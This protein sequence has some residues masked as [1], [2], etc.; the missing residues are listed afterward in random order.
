MKFDDFLNQAWNDHAAQP[1]K[2]SKTCVDAIKLIESDEQIPQLAQII[3]HVFGEHLGKWDEG[4]EALQKLRQIPALKISSES[5]LAILRYVRCLELAS[6]C[7]SSMDNFSH[8]DQVRIF[9]V[10]AS[11]LSGQNQIERAH[12]FF[13]RAVDCAQTSVSKDD[14]ANRA[15]AMTCNNLAVALEEK[16]NR[17]AFETDLMI[18]A[19]KAARKF[20]ELSGTWLEVERAEYRLSQSYLKAN[21]LIQSLEHAQ[22]CLKIVEENKA[23]PLEFFF[24]Y[25][26]LALVEKAR[27]N[28]T[29]Y[30]TAVDQMKSYFEKLSEEDK[31]WCSGTLKKL[32]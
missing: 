30:S 23:L 12:K 28:T 22:L 32:S 29:G 5:E 14:V 4:I 15:L 13:L 10:A 6:G 27:V 21:D 9:A 25:E 7:D 31:S 24:A 19:A 1:E 26:A 3:T 17:S 8:S 2:V 11:A 18:L 20:W 16:Q